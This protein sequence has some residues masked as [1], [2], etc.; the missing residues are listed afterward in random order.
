MASYSARL[1]TWDAAE[2]SG[3]GAN[4]RVSLRTLVMVE[5]GED[6]AGF[7]GGRGGEKDEGWLN[8]GGA[9]S[10]GSGLAEDPVVDS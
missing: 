7:L 10:Q 9:E 1:L 6:M 3:V 5:A 2:N 4:E 8:G